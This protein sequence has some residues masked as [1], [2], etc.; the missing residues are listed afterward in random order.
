MGREFEVW[1][2]EDI[3]LPN[4]EEHLSYVQKY[5]GDDFDEAMATAKALKKSGAGCVKIMWR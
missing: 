3:S 2:W 4:K 1:S 5:Y